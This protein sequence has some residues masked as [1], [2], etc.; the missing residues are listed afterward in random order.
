VR[1]VI[2]TENRIYGGQA[3]IEGVMMRNARAMAVAVRNPDGKIELFKQT[4]TGP[5]RGRI[6]QTP[7]VRGVVGL[8]DAFGLGVRSLM[9]SASVAGG[10]EADYEGSL[11]WGTMAISLMLGI[12]LFFLLPAALGQAGEEWVGLSVG[13]GNL[14]E[15]FARLGLVVGYIWAIGFVPDIRRIY[16]YHGAEHKTIHAFEA[17]AELTP[18]SV[19]RFPREHP[20]CGTAFLLVVIV[21]SVLIFAAFGPLP[22]LWRLGTRLLLLPVL[23][24][25]AYEYLRLTGRNMHIG[26]VRLLVRPT[27]ALQRLTTRDP[28]DDMLAVA[29]SAFTAVRAADGRVAAVHHNGKS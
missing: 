18:E 11:A 1:A 9:Y 17:D 27:L 26:F 3:V 15:G 24:S 25:L 5:L 6:A 21:L 2:F 29:I 4:L 7:F 23:A 12:G 14:L 28:D 19:A 8:V 22:L 20:R 16:G 13:A 10:E